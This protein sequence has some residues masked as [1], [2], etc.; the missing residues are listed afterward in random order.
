[1]TCPTSSDTESG[2]FRGT[3]GAGMVADGSTSDGDD[4]D[5][6]VG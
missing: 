1:V 2:W 4:T 3:G 6:H 5:W